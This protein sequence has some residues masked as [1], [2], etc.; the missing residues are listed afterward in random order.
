MTSSGGPGWRRIRPE[1]PTATLIERLGRWITL[2]HRVRPS[3]VA[4]LVGYL[5]LVLLGVTTSSLGMSSQR[6][7]PAHPLG[8]TVGTPQNIRSDEW[9]TEAP[10][11]LGAMASGGADIGSPLAQHIDLIY[12]IPTSGLVGSVVFFD[13]SALRLGPHVDQ[14]ML[15]A[16]YKWFPFLLLLVFLPLL[17]Q[18]WGATAGLSWFATAIFVLSPVTV[19][20]S[21]MPVRIA[22]FT[23]AGCYLLTI[24]VAQYRARHFVAAGFAGP[25]AAVLLARMPT[26]YVPW[27]I[28]LCIPIMI[29]TVVWIVFPTGGRRSALVVVGA[30]GLLTVALAG[31]LFWENLPALRAELGTT[32]PGQRRSGSNWTPLGRL[33][34]APNLFDLQR[35]PH[36]TATNASEVTSGFT[37]C[38]LWVVVLLAVLGR[39]AFRGR[40]GAAIVALGA[41]TLFWLLW[42]T[43][44]TGGFGESVPVANLVPAFRAAQTVG[45]PLVLVLSLVLSRLPPSERTWR[46]APVAA[47]L[48]AA[49]TL[50]GGIGL[51]L[52]NIRGMSVWTIALGGLAVFPLV[53]LITRQPR[54][55]WPLVLAVAIVAVPA[56]RVNPLIFG[57]GDLRDSATAQRMLAEG[58]AA[59]AANTWWA[60]DSV[61][62]DSLLNATGVPSLSGKQVTGPVVS[63]WKKF[64]PTGA[65]EQ[66]WNRG[67]SYLTMSWTVGRKV[68]VTAGPNG[69]I[70]LE[71][72]PCDPLLRGFRLR[73]VLSAAALTA[74][75]LVPMG[76][77]TWQG[78]PK[79]LYGVSGS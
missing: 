35:Q 9:L 11:E 61:Y 51:K 79:Y 75:C 16:A 71:I 22:A 63:Q 53:L 64:D 74:P 29:T 2:G 3:I 77:V 48:C 50:A 65:S 69:P 67:A 49:A 68:H 33:L 52:E 78:Q 39:R 55:P 37:F 43:V 4:V 28:T 6:Q 13:G 47:G 58:V 1:V 45:L 31:G 72:D 19:W 12:Q 42:V 62:T 23:V 60:T 56:V 26:Y 21:F 25:G 18:R 34:G 15:F 7:D 59:R 41:C 36:L 73:A 10:L 17:L 57:L 24:A 8:L 30:V 5:L 38:A 54:R 76:S 70:R 44:P 40:E 27:A 20:W 32:Y 66:A 14:E 46:M